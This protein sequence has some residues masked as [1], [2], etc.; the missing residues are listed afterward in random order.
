[1]KRVIGSIV[2]VVVLVVLGF[3]A[4][5]WMRQGGNPAAVAQAPA[6][7]AVASAPLAQSDV[8]AS[9]E[10]AVEGVYNRVGPSVVYIEVSQAAPQQ[11]SRFNRQQQLPQREGSGSGFVWD[12][13]GN[14]VTNNHVVEGAT[15]I[16]VTFSDGTILPATVV[17][18]D[19]SSDLAVIKVNAAEAPLYPV[20]LADSTRVKVGQVAIAIG[21]PFG[22]ENT[23]TVG[24]VS[25]LGRSLPAQARTSNGSSASYSIPDVIQTDAPINPG[26]SG[27]VL[28]NST[29]QVIGVTTAIASQSGSS[30]GV[31]FAVPSAIVAKV[32]PGL[33]RD[34]RYT[35]SWLGISG[36]TLTPD[37]AEA[38]E[39][40][41][42]QRGALVAEVTSG[43]PAEVAGLKA[44]A[45]TTT[46]AGREVK[47][48]GDVI[49]A[50][51]GQRVST[52]EAVVA[53]LV[54]ATTP[55]Q[56]IT[57][58]VLRGGQEQ[59]LSVTLGE[60]PAT[61]TRVAESAQ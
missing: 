12:K 13:Q 33:V 61:T 54:R 53:Y 2:I 28:L 5:A 57:L 26:N 41:S 40:K 31:G 43:G 37:L 56:K 15:K 47:V 52:F 10:S 16:N 6:A 7:A 29:G 17:G 44:S 48:G 58:T 9:L 4:P 22:L 60:R 45:Q 27:G 50:V 59:Q 55:G 3:M 51:D 23:L 42:T 18:Q 11:T 38:M 39:L 32:V 20:V 21:N 49:V 30:S 35:Q 24:Y 36:T 14:I 34:G 1:M 8:I 25:A 46:I 19:A